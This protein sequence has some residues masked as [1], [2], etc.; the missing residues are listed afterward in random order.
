VGQNLQDKYDVSL[1]KRKMRN[2]RQMAHHARSM[3]FVTAKSALA[4]GWKDD[5]DLGS[6]LELLS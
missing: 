4:G 6:S 5:S 2:K 1:S 3:T